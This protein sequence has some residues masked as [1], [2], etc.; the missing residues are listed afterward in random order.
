[1]GKVIY[2]P[3]HGDIE[4]WI[5]CGLQLPELKVVVK[6]YAVDGSILT[7]CRVMEYDSESKYNLGAEFTDC[8]MNLEHAKNHPVEEILPINFI[9]HW[10]FLVKVSQEKE[11]SQKAV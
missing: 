8:W 2:E 3:K 6:G 1:M 5:P 4:D 7:L 10:D 11:N 9:T